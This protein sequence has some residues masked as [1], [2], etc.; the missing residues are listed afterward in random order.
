[1]HEN[2]LLQGD[3]NASH[4]ACFALSLRK[5]RNACSPAMFQYAVARLPVS[6]YFN[7]EIFVSSSVIFSAKLCLVS[8]YIKA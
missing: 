6:I 1:M 2:C 8:K 7:L 4:V 5:V 3:A